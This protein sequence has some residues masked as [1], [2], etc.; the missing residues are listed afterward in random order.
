M[1]RIAELVS[2]PDDKDMKD[3]R[4]HVVMMMKTALLRRVNL[5]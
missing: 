4:L 1:A 2:N 3:I 5:P